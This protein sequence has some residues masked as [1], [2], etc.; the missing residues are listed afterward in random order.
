MKKWGG[1]CP[2]HPPTHP[3]PSESSEPET[4]GTKEW[5]LGERGGRFPSPPLSLSPSS[6]SGTCLHCSTF[7]WTPSEKG[8]G[9]Q[10]LINP[11]M[12]AGGGGGERACWRTPV[13]R[14]EERGC[15]RQARRGGG[16]P[17]LGK[18]GAEEEE[19]GDRFVIPSSTI[20]EQVI[21][22]TTRGWRLLCA[23]SL[24]PSLPPRC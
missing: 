18:V 13:T 24:P 15:S 6:S 9:R 22:S 8:E 16:I 19:E 23:R 1:G 3:L 11:A 14:G 21:G 7:G 4:K 2:F 20:R 10:E 5:G 12:R 17:R